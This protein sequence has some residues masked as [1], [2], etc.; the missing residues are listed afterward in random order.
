MGDDKFSADDAKKMIADDLG[1]IRGEGTALI[2][3]VPTIDAFASHSPLQ[4]HPSPESLEA[5]F[6]KKLYSLQG[7]RNT[8]Y[9]G[10]AWAGDYSSVLWQFTERILPS[11]I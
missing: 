10:H 7:H 3:K 2:G 11:M 8:F 6:Y 5:G 4:L 1:R 9:T